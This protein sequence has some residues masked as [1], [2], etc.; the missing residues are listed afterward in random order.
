MLASTGVSWKKY[1]IPSCGRCFEL[2]MKGD[3]K[4]DC[5]E[6]VNWDTCNQSGKVDY[7]FPEKIPPLEKGAFQK[8]TPQKLS[9]SLLKTVIDIANGGLIHGNWRKEN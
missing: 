8:L 6:C 3:D 4:Q 7:N 1:K 2:L 5:I 9:N